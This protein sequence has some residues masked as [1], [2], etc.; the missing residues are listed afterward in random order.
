MAN[1]DGSCFRGDEHNYNL[2][3]S[4][5]EGSN[6][7]SFP[8]T[9]VDWTCNSVSEEMPQTSIDGLQQWNTSIFT[10]QYQQPVFRLPVSSGY[11][12]QNFQGTNS[13]IGYSVEF[14]T[15]LNPNEV[16]L[17]EMAAGSS[18]TPTAGEFIPR[19]ASVQLSSEL[20]RGA[21]ELDINC[22]NAS[23]QSRPV[24]SSTYSD[25][26]QGNH[27]FRRDGGD[28]KHFHSHR[29]SSSGAVRDVFHSN[30]KG[31]ARGILQNTATNF[32]SYSME[33]A[34]NQD[35]QRL[36]A[37]AAA[38]LTSSGNPDIAPVSGV[39][40]NLSIQVK[41]QNMN[42]GSVY[43]PK[44]KGEFNRTYTYPSKH[45]G[46]VSDVN[47]SYNVQQQPES[48][49]QQKRRNDSYH[50]QHY[51]SS[52]H[53]QRNVTV[54]EMSIGSKLNNQYRLPNCN[55]ISGYRGTGAARRASPRKDADQYGERSGNTTG[56]YELLIKEFI[57]EANFFE[58]KD[59]TT[60]LH[61][62][63]V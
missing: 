11:V 7:Q 31:N 36:L 30:R 45:N 55:T 3:P 25:C 26:D 4:G 14:N 20:G 34:K 56:N 27:G 2:I 63:K 29:N 6:V 1:W 42:V 5:C 59:Q 39:D 40:S 53:N 49:S 17:E 35:R 32:K 50:S 9:S 33:K 58:S 57:V 43:R 41:Q 15:N 60:F 61:I 24:A 54:S 51:Q 21:E 48:F 22:R 23:E 44:G 12:D 19:P 8:G 16:H 47:F 38:F 52:F 37:E 62:L 10:N 28:S 18:L 46:D 13:N